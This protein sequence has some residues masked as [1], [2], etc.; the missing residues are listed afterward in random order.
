MFRILF[1]FCL[2]VTNSASAWW[3]SCHMAVA[4]I[5]QER[6]T[7]RAK[8]HAEDLISVLE[9]F[10]PTSPDFITAACWAD[11]VKNSLF[12]FSLWHKQ[13]TPYDPENI[14]NQSNCCV[15]PYERK[16]LN[17]GINQCVD[18]L[19]NQESN[20]YDRAIALRL[21]I[22]LVADAHMPLHCAAFPSTE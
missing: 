19:K 18:C 14:L 20:Y 22:H 7:E 12:S 16:Y 8:F 13:L 17:H 3:D 11:D 6:L 10:Y 2:I 9:D 15:K 1:L 21:L 5:A 4:Q